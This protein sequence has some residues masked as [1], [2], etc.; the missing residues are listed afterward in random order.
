MEPLV[1]TELTRMIRVRQDH[2]RDALA[3]LEAEQSADTK[4]Q[5]L[6]R[7]A[8]EVFRS[9]ELLVGALLEAVEPDHPRRRGDGTTRALDDPADAT[10]E[11][12][13][14]RE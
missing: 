1:S 11:R 5:S 13:R 6:C 10:S 3:L 4:V 14:E 8:M 7:S 9:Y 2:L 12:D